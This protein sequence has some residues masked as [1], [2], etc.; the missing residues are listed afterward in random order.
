M[1]SDH[2]RLSPSAAE[3][4]VNCPP[5]LAESERNPLPEGKKSS[6]YAD[7]GTAAHELAERTLRE[8]WPSAADLEGEMAEN[9]WLFDEQMCKDVDIY[10]KA[11]RAFADGH[12]I[13]IE[14]RIDYSHVVGVPDSFGTADGVVLTADGQELQLHDL[15]FGRGVPVSANNN[16]QL[17]LYALG[18]LRAFDML[19]EIQTVR[20]VIHQVRLGYCDEWACSVEDL[21]KFGERAKVAAQ[22]AVEL[23]DN[24]TPDELIAQ[25]N[26]GPKQCQWCPVKATCPARLADAADSMQLN[27]QELLNGGPDVV[28]AVI[29][30]TA[31]LGPA[32]LAALMPKLDYINDWTKAIRAKVELWLLE[33][34]EV[35]G[36]KL[37][38]GKR[39]SRAWS[40]KDEVEQ[41]LKS[42]FRLKTDEMYDFSLRSPTTIEKLLKGSPHRWG[43]CL[44]FVTQAEGKPS[45][46]PMSDKRP[47]LEMTPD[48]R[49]L[50]MPDEPT[51]T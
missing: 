9:G 46:A 1:P 43:Q 21:F 18:A 4:W 3:R 38:E 47:A 15:K 48:L 45:V 30:N 32:Q 22:K 8:G 33:G 28:E 6:K 40:N 16:M 50:L 7:E 42:K 13:L 17:M 27:M 44:E 10:V 35:P 34:V 23:A 36:Y 5:S 49:E 41:L 51:E 39:G 26:P 14:Q 19:G 25:M 29:A 31:Q 24:A 37:V 12:Q 11:L 20:L 2:A